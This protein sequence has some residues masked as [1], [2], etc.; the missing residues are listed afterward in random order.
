MSTHILSFNI[1]AYFYEKYKGGKENSK[2]EIRS[3][4][5]RFPLGNVLCYDFLSVLVNFKTTVAHANQLP[6]L[7]FLLYLKNLCKSVPSTPYMGVGGFL[8]KTAGK[9]A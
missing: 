7:V 5:L 9:I 4:G 1:L 8:D 6:I 2:L 3:S